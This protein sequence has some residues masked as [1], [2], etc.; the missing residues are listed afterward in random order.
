[1]F[2]QKKKAPATIENVLHTQVH[3]FTKNRTYDVV[4]SSDFLTPDDHVL[5]VD[6]FLAFGNAALGVIDLIKQSGATLVGMGFIIE[7]A[8]QDGRKILED[9]GIR[10]E[11]LAIIDDLSNCTITLKDK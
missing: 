7:K 2:L 8:F 11:S 5:F 4:I 3:S 6:D 1:M 10:V 9:Q